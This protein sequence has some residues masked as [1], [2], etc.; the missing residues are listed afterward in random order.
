MRP[1]LR[2]LSMT[3]SNRGYRWF[4]VLAATM[5][6]CSATIATDGGV[7][8]GDALDAEPADAGPWRPM[9]PPRRVIEHPEVSCPAW[10]APTYEPTS[11]PAA[12]AGDLL[13]VVRLSATPAY[14]EVAR[15][16]LPGMHGL[17]EINRV[18]LTGLPQ[19]G[20]QATVNYFG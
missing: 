18:G 13:R 5:A 11:R 14:A 10:P 7:D 6:A 9:F 19:G 2:A 15:A 12:E 20:V 17:F 8:V 4:A 3:A 16:G 1:S